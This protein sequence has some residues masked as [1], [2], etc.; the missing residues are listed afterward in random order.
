M[1]SQGQVGCVIV[2]ADRVAANGDI[3]NQVGT[4]PLAVIAH[5]NDIPFYV[6][7]PTSTLDLSLASGDG[8]PLEEGDPEEVSRWGNSTTTPKGI[9]VRNVVFDVTPHRYIS[10][11]ITERGIV[12]APYDQGLAKLLETEHQT[13]EAVPVSEEVGVNGEAV[14]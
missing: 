3:V 4:Y 6:A 10:S 13:A 8:I 11:I 7:A 2:G 14:G 9:T 1:L 12:T 5:E